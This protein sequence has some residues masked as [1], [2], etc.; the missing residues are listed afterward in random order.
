MNA[1]GIISPN[2]TIMTLE[3]IIAN[4][5][6]AIWC[7]IMGIVSQAKALPTNRVD[8]SRWCWEITGSRIAAYDDN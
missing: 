7:K 8:R 4:Q 6:G 5:S 2:K 3:M 1:E